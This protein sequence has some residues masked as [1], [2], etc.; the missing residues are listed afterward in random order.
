MKYLDRLEFDC[1]GDD[2]KCGFVTQWRFS[3]PKTGVQCSEA[4]VVF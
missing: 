1:I 3:P 4:L 2:L